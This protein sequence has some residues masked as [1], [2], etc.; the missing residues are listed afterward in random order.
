[1]SAA[2]LSM[3]QKWQ[4]AVEETL[5]RVIIQYYQNPP[6]LRSAS[7]ILQ[8]VDRYWGHMNRNLFDSP[9]HYYT[10]LAKTTDHLL[11]FLNPAVDLNLSPFL[12][13]ER[14]E[15]GTKRTKTYVDIDVAY[16]HHEFCT[17]RKFVWQEDESFYLHYTRSAVNACEGRFGIR[18][19]KIE[20][21]SLLTGERKIQY[22]DAH[23]RLQ[24]IMAK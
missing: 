8:L 4:Q 5:K 9:V 20:F 23:G 2:S 12:L 1:M 17:I 6:S 3:Y 10:V 18:L 19:K 13:F 21:C 14:I 11:R 7:L 22:V 15:Y 24:P 16:H